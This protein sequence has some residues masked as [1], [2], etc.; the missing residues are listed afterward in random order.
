MSDVLK[1]DLSMRKVEEEK[2]EKLLRPEQI[3]R[4]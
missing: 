2:R 1:N 4:W 3:A